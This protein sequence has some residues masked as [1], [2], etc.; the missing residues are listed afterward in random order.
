MNDNYN[1][2]RPIKMYKI[3]EEDREK[4]AKD[5]SEGSPELEK[6]LRILWDNSL[7]T[8][9]CCRG[10]HLEAKETIYGNSDIHVSWIGYISFAPG[11]DVF[12]YLSPEVIN[13]RNIMLE[14]GK[15]GDE[16]MQTIRFF[17]S[18]T[19]PLLFE[20]I[21]YDVLTGEKDNRRELADK[22]QPILHGIP[23]ELDEAAKEYVLRKNGLDDEKIKEFRLSEDRFY[24]AFKEIRNMEE[25]TQEYNDKLTELAIAKGNID[26]I[27]IPY[28]KTNNNTSYNEEVNIGISK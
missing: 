27:L 20:K 9:A 25:G 23:R 13:N 19:T 6:C 2:G 7:Y 1:N 18:E 16:N 14:Q 22:V 3:P 10:D 26:R 4:A 15:I 17:C 21:G 24:E 8:T 12:K 28:A 5:F 11:I